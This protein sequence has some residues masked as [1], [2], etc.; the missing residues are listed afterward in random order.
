MNE[1][2]N[3]QDNPQEE[4]RRHGYTE[5]MAKLEE[6]SKV[7][8]AI[9]G[10]QSAIKQYL[11]IQFGGEDLLGTDMEGNIKRSLRELNEKIEAQNLSMV[12]VERRV[13]TLEN[14]WIKLVGIG[15]GSSAVGTFILKIMIK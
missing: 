12:A 14:Q 3:N 9:K 15:I 13:R 2:L 11:L 5:L 8:H 4:E 7:T 10:N 1:P 6:L